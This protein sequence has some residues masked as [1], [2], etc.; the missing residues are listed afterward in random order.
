MNNEATKTD[1]VED[2]IVL[3]RTYEARKG[4]VDS[5]TKDVEAARRNLGIKLDQLKKAEEELEAVK[6]RIRNIAKGLHL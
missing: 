1:P 2:L 6:D 4:N 3:V 5:I